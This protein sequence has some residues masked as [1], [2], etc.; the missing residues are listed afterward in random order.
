MVWKQYV[1]PIVKSP[2]VVLGKRKRTDEGDGD[3]ASKIIPW[4]LHLRIQDALE[5]R[6]EVM[7]YKL[8][9]KKAL[10]GKNYSESELV[11]EDKNDSESDSDDYLD[12]QLKE[13]EDHIRSLAKRFKKLKQLPHDWEY[14]PATASTFVAAEDDISALPKMPPPKEKRWGCWSW[15]MDPNQKFPKTTDVPLDEEEKKIWMDFKEFDKDKL[16]LDEVVDFDTVHEHDIPLVLDNPIVSLTS[17]FAV[18]A[19]NEAIEMYVKKGEQN[20]IHDFDVVKCDYL[21]MNGSS[22]YFYITIEAFEERK[23]GVYDTKVRLNW[24][25]GS[26]SLMHFVLTDR[27]PR[28]L[29][30]TTKLRTHPVTSEW[31]DLDYVSSQSVNQLIKDTHHMG[32]TVH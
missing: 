23:R 17:K 21:K 16:G 5:F 27:K 25:D 12:F 8:E 15:V 26:K 29:K 3:A 31:L 2:S 13:C 24:D 14:D 1:M 28:G 18:T 10:T 4:E 20:N 9:A 7:L 11:S 30:E 22:Y 19:F 32:R 6:A